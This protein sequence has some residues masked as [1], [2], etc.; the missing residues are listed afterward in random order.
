[1]LRM[2]KAVPAHVTT[3]LPQLF[4]NCLFLIYDNALVNFFIMVGGIPVIMR[5]VKGKI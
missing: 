2:I 1:M 5:Q 3:A 4:L